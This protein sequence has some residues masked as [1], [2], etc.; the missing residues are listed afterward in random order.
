MKASGDQ[1][2]E[3]IVEVAWDEELQSWKFM[4]FRDDKHDGNFIDI[5][6][7]IMSSI[8]DGVVQE[9]VSPATRTSTLV[10]NEL[11][12]IALR[13]SWSN[14]YLR[15]EQDGNRER[16]KRLPRHVRPSRNEPPNQ[17]PT[18][19]HRDRRLLLPLI[20]ARV[21]PVPLAIRCP[22]RVVIWVVSQVGAYGVDD[23]MNGSCPLIVCNNGCIY[24]V[25]AD[26]SEMTDSG[27]ESDAVVVVRG[28]VI[29]PGRRSSAA[30]LW[31]C[32][33]LFPRF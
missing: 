19:R 2:D 5:G 29:R 22:Q 28:P 12:F 11:R 31:H 15:S 27:N 9:Q 10:M 1:Y 30:L 32:R 4:R 25:R 24:G 26:R 20:P 6:D 23:F 13:S 8:M 17:N 33:F 21:C 14:G 16:Q 18:S 3:R 7:K